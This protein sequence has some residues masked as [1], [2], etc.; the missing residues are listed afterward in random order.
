MPPRPTPQGVHSATFHPAPRDHT[1]SIPELYEY[2]ALNSPA[3]VVFMYSDV[4]SGTSTFV[5]YAEAWEGICRAAGIVAQHVAASGSTSAEERPVIAVL[6]LSDSLSYIYLLI[7]IMS[8]GWTAFPMSPRNSA[9]GTAR[10]LKET[11]ASR[12]FTN[13]DGP[14][15]SLARD[16]AALLA[17]DGVELELL[18]MLTYGDLHGGSGDAQDAKD[19]KIIR[20]AHDDTMLILHSSGTSGFPKP[21]ECTT[22]G[23]INLSNIPHAMGSA[24]YLWPPASGAI[25]AVYSPR[26]RPTIPTPANFLASWIADNCHIVF[27]VPVFIEAWAQD[28]KN[29]PRLKAL[30]SIVFSGASVNKRTGDMLANEGVILHPFW[31]STEVGPAT[32]FVPRD[33]PPA[34]EWEYFKFSNHITVA[35]EAW[36]GL[37]GVFQPIVIPTPICFPHVLNTTHEGQPAFDVGDLLV[38]H[39][40]DL[41]RWRVYGRADDQI[42][43]ATGENVNPLPIENM[44]SHDAHIACVLMFGRHRPHTGILVEPAPEFALDD[45]GDQEQLKK[46]RELIWPTI[47]RAN[48]PTAAYAHITKNMIIVVS[49][50]KT[51]RI[52]ALYRAEEVPLAEQQFPDRA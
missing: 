1:L 23:L 45:A 31:G 39:P 15:N 22:K 43:L 12:I 25:F 19:F 34:G 33:P 24:T 28:P 35:M 36:D 49:R 46:F 18:S 8:L 50:E 7:G 10:L 14:I 13:T 29:I 5:T 42:M 47:E 38:R 26:P 11:G 52:E 3:H 17:S 16:A 51:I 32:M 4:E 27:C 20:M 30:D 6:A 37:E 9:E 2:H 41:A 40:T 48:A 44:I 21:I